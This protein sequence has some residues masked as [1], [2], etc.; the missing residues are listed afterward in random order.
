MC[1]CVFP[2]F[3]HRRMSKAEKDRSPS[4]SNSPSSPNTT[5]STREAGEP[6]NNHS[7]NV[8]MPAAGPSASPTTVPLLVFCTK[9]TR[10]KLLATR[11]VCFL[12]GKKKGQGENGYGKVKTGKRRPAPSQR[13]R[14]KSSRDYFQPPST[15]KDACLLKKRQ[16]KVSEPLEVLDPFF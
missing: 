7:L 15:F 13:L 12:A 10:F 14:R 3:F 4:P 1:V 8:L 11:L 5:S 9:P 6:T 16:R 2:N